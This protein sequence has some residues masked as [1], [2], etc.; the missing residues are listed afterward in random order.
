[1]SQ[2][3]I[4]LT[5]KDIDEDTKLLAKNI[6]NS[7]IRYDAIIAISGGGLIPARIIR[8]YINIPIY[9]VNIKTYNEKN[10]QN[11]DV[12]IVQWLGKNEIAELSNKNVLFIDD[13]DDTRNTLQWI[14]KLINDE[15]EE[16]NCNKVGFGLLYNKIKQKSY[17]IPDEFQYYT[18][19]EIEDKWVVFP[20]EI[21]N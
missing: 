20:W 11:N 2:K 9:C 6:L 16:L 10:E 7:S 18:A 12:K 13:L 14:I 4:Y 21:Y 19:K 15:N 8:N 5:Y 3:K 1:M 17:I